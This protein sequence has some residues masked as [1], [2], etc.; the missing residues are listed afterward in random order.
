MKCGTT[1]LYHYLRQHPQIFMTVNKEPNFFSNKYVMKYSHGPG[2][3]F[4]GVSEKEYHELFS[5][6]KKEK[7]I[8][9]ASTN[10]IYCPEA[11][12]QI[13]KLIPDV[14]LIAMLRNPADRAY[15]AYMHISR[16]KYEPV[17]DFASALRE[18]KNR[19]LA[20]WE[21][22]WHYKNGGFYYK[23]LKNYY[24]LFDRNNIRVYIFE[25][26]I[27]N[28]ILVVKDIFKFLDVEES[29][30]P[31]ISMKYNVTGIPKSK[32]LEGIILKKYL[33][34]KILKLL[35]PR[36]NRIYLRSLVKLMNTKKSPCPPDIRKQLLEEFQED[37]LQ[38]EDLI[39]RD[40]SLWFE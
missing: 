13:K 27:Q 39:Q 35:I 21:P 11:C 31:N 19:I 28:P 10:Y 36:K 2:Y 6:V 4:R 24:D 1:S 7:A 14:K 3:Q 34:K 38:L 40:L 22:L 20:C 25:E 37:I 15:S 12:K 23:Q 26:F 5:K 8:G 16:D 29:F 30:I 9:E 33:L 17:T 32:F 18:E